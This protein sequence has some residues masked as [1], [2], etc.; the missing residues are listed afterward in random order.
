MSFPCKLLKLV[1]YVWV[2][3]AISSGFHSAVANDKLDSALLKK[4]SQ[5]EQQLSTTEK[6]I[7]GEKSHLAKQLNQLEQQVEALQQKTAAA[8]RLSD[9]KTLSLGQLEGRIKEWREQQAYQQNLL[10]R[11]LH[12]QQLVTQVSLIPV[13]QK[14][15]L[16][17]E[18]ASQFQ[19]KL[20][21]AWQQ[22]GR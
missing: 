6:R 21:P 5:A 17:L 16:L 3:V 20:Q 13:E 18:F 7:S 22:Q 12:Q 11:F 1:I 4:I 2:M 9:E 19:T 8:R 14:F 10:N 15:A